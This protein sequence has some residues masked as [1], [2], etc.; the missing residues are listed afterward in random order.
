[1]DKGIDTGGIIVQRFFK[2]NII[3]N[4]ADVH[5][6]ANNLFSAMVVEV[7]NNFQN[8][9]LKVIKQEDTQVTYWHQRA[10]LDGR[11]NWHDMTALQAYNFIRA[12]TLPYKGAH[13]FCNGQKLR[14]Y[15]SK[16]IKNSFCGYPGRVVKINNDELIVICSDKGLCIENYK[17]EENSEKLINGIHLN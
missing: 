8:K 5:K 9:I 3:D 2:L 4:I 10:D 16:L 15:S 12:L 11:I 17:F 6:K 14:I 1:M 13:T 7:L